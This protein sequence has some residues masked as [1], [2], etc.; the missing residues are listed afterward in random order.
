MLGTSIK[1]KGLGSNKQKPQ[2]KN[3]E[4]HL[5]ENRKKKDDKEQMTDRDLDV[6]GQTQKTVFNSGNRDNS[7]LSGEQRQIDVLA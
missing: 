7:R 4:K 6:H 1:V 5:K 2:N 3:F